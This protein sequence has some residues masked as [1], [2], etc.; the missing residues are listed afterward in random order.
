MNTVH[1]QVLPC[2]GMAKSQN[3]R[4]KSLALKPERAFLSPI[5]HCRA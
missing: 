2:G 1:F 3:L 5:E 4:V